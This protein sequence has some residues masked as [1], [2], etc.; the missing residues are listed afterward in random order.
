MFK[1][2]FE[3]GEH[4]NTGQKASTASQGITI[5]VFSLAACV[6]NLYGLR[7][8]QNNFG[9]FRHLCG[10][11]LFYLLLGFYSLPLI[12]MLKQMSEF[13][14]SEGTMSSV[15][16]VAVIFAIVVGCLH[17]CLLGYRLNRRGESSQELKASSPSGTANTVGNAA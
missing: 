16:L 13:E 5:M 9:F 3:H 10:R 4:F 17:L 7:C 6:D 8:L 12:E 11:G 14:N 2:P 1:L 15:A